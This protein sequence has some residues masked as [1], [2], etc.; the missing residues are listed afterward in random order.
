M[1]DDI[2]FDVFDTNKNSYLEPVEL[3]H[4]YSKKIPAIIIIGNLYFFVGSILSYYFSKYFVYDDFNDDPKQNTFKDH[5]YILISLIKEVS[6]LLILV[7]IT[8]KLVK[9]IVLPLNNSSL[10]N[11]IDLT[12]IKEING[13][14]ILATAFLM[15]IRSTIKNKFQYLINL[16][17]L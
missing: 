6:I 13:N 15:F 7:Y 9:Y 10:T 8:R 2:N 14:I 11:G 3:L 4:F 16:F 5:I 12:R 1:S 17:N